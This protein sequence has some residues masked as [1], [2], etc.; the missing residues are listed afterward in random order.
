MSICV[1]NRYSPL[2]IFAGLTTDEWV[3]IDDPRKND[4]TF[5]LGSETKS[6]RIDVDRLT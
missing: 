4:E 2:C 1:C 3:D 6:R 5:D